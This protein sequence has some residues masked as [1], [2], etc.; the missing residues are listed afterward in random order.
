MRYQSIEKVDFFGLSLGRE[1]APDPA[2]ALT[3]LSRVAAEFTSRRCAPVAD[4]Y[5]IVIP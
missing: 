4:A 1:I 2:G 3:V 5:D